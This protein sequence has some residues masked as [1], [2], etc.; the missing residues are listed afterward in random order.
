[1]LSV[2]ALTM[3]ATIIQICKESNI[4]K[5]QTQ[6]NPIS[7]DEEEQSS[8]GDESI[9]ED[10]ICLND[11]EHFYSS[12]NICVYNWKIFSL[13]LTSISLDIQIP[14]PKHKLIVLTLL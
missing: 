13:N 9:D 4:F 3:Q 12:E 5:D 1:M 6:Q 10:I 7:D 2:F 8:D 11:V 14:P